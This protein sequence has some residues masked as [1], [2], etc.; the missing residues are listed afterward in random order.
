VTG[1]KP[2][3]GRVSRF[4]VFPLAPSLDHIGPIARSAA[5]A[6][7]MLGVIAGLDRRDPTTLAAPV[8]DYLADLE[9]GVRGLRIGIDASYNESGVEPEIV[10]MLR[11]VRRVL[12]DRGATIVETKLPDIAAVSA[13]WATIAGLETSLVHAATFP[14]RASEYGPA[15]G[16]TIAALIEHGRTVTASDLMRAHYD[17][18]AFSGALAALFSNIDLLLIPTQ[19]LANFTVAQEAK[20]FERADDLGAFIRYATPFDMS[21]S[22]TI[23]LPGGFTTKGLP[24]S[25]QFVGRHLEESLL[26]RA[27]H[28]YQ[29]ATT[30]HRRHPSIVPSRSK[31]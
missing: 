7:A 13:A 12:E 11:D 17:R 1:L 15:V 10:A 9:Q 22:P 6:G 30:W 28:A 16:G 23:T 26:V 4:G 25:F 21:G 24:V 5:D 20:L 29:Q 31:S 19:P 18:L 3:W 14:S 27:G 2:T 8:P